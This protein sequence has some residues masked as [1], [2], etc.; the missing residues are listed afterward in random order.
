[1]L[2]SVFAGVWRYRRNKLVLAA[3]ALVIYILTAMMVDVQ[4]VITRPGLFWSIFW[5]PLAFTIGAVN[6]AQLAAPINTL[7]EDY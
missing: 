6:R 3:F 7:S 1:M 5:F 2:T 4:H